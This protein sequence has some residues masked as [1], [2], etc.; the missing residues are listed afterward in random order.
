MGI[1]GSI[2]VKDIY[3]DKDGSGKKWYTVLMAGQ[4]RGG[5]SYFALDITKPLSARIFI[6]F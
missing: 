3:Y 5:H 1:D 6:C 2:V 4:G